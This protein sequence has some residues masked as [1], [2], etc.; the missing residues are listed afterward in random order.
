MANITDKQLTEALVGI[1][2]AQSALIRA[3]TAPN[4][5]LKTIDQGITRN[6][7]GLLGNADKAGK[8]SLVDL[9]AHILRNA[10]SGLK[11]EFVSWLQATIAQC[12]A[13]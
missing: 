12:A 7:N 10:R 2:L 13:E 5:D 11:P 9:P 3:L 1:A 8:Y 4:A 6:I